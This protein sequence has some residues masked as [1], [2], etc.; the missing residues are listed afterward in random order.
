MQQLLS[1]GVSLAAI[2]RQLR[3]DHST[4]RRFVRARSLGELLVK[5]T[6]RTSILDGHKLYLHQR[7]R[8]G[9]HDIPQP[10]REL[11]ARGFTGDI[12][13]VRRS[14]AGQNWSAGS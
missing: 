1:E 9:Y 4:V 5:A 11:R 14:A 7:W 6:N 10:H 2:G 3:L 8:E 12:Q 13:R